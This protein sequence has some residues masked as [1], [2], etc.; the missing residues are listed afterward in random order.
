MVELRFLEDVTV[1]LDTADGAALEV[2]ITYISF[3]SS[4][5]RWFLNF[6]RQVRS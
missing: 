6:V 3:L 1:K 5:I 4:V 2:N